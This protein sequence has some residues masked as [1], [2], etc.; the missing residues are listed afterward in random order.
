MKRSTLNVMMVAIAVAVLSIGIVSFTSDDGTSDAAP[1][2]GDNGQF[3]L[4]TALENAVSGE[5]VTMPENC[6]ITR[7]ALVKSG[8]T[9]VTDGK[10]LTITNLSKLVVE[11]TITVNGNLTI[12]DRSSLTIASGNSSIVSGEVRVAGAI[13]VL[14]DGT[15]NIQ[16]N[17]AVAIINE[18]ASSIDVEGKMNVSDGTVNIRDLRVTG[19]LTINEKVVFYV[20]ADAIIG[21]PHT[22]TTEMSCDAKVTGKITLTKNTLVVTYDKDSFNGSNIKYPHTSTELFLRDSST[23]AVEYGDSGSTRNVYLPDAEELKDYKLINWRDINGVVVDDTSSSKIGSYNKLFGETELRSYNVYL[24]ND[25]SIRWIV[26]NESQG[27]GGI[28]ERPYGANVK[29]EVTLNPGYEN[30]PNI[31]VNG[32]DYEPLSSFKITADTTFTTSPVT[33][34]PGYDLTTILL[35]ILVVVILIMFFIIFYVKFLKPTPQ[36]PKKKK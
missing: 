14:K 20:I 19:E 31:K 6:T 24:I 2:I 34:D 27:S 29:V 23:Y 17:D 21:S 7:D 16:S 18:G 28:I 8:V 25:E 30:L 15:L 26:N 22:L 33:P 5:V 32:M 36:P 13:A 3:D 10:H 35:I 9:L 12:S 11:G 4:V 1:N